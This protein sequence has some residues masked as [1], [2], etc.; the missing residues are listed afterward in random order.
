MRLVR[1]ELQPVNRPGVAIVLARADRRHAEGLRVAHQAGDLRQSALEGQLLLRLGPLVRRQWPFG[2]SE[3]L[4]LVDHLQRHTMLV[5]A[6]PHSRHVVVGHVSASA[7][8]VLGVVKHQVDEPVGCQLLVQRRRRRRRGRLDGRKVADSCTAGGC[9]DEGAVKEQL[10]AL[11][12]DLLSCA[13]G[14][15]RR[16][17]SGLAVE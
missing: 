10:A 4:H 9:L 2:L 6:A 14:L 3:R 8:G 13:V 11:L 1:L 16:S 15:G 7:S 17:G 5:L 12:L